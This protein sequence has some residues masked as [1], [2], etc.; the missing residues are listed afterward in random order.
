[1]ILT[2]R[3]E[4]GQQEDPNPAETTH[5]ASKFI[6]ETSKQR[7]YPVLLAINNETFG[8]SEKNLK[9]ITNFTNIFRTLFL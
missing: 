5:K 9:N 8:K 3:T 1:M 7:Q 2:V 4:P 6:N